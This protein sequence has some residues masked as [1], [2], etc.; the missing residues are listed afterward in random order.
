MFKIFLIIP[1]K[2]TSTKED[3]LSAIWESWNHFNK[4]YCF[5]LVDIPAWKN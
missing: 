1:G 5:K 4:E 3:L 2:A